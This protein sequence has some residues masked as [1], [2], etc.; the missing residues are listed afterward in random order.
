MTPSPPDE[1]EAIVRWLRDDAYRI[2]GEARRILGKVYMPT[3]ADSDEWR[4]LI[5][6]KHGL[7]DAIEA[8]VHLSEQG[9]GYE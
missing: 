1:R 8:G 7:A 3:Q 6:M 9:E 4:F 5:S 2:E